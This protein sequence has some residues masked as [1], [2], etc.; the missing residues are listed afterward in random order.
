MFQIL[1]ICM[2]IISELPI[3]KD[4]G[5]S[6]TSGHQCIR[7]YLPVVIDN[8]KADILNKIDTHS[9]YGFVFYIKRM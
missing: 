3:L 5:S 9:L 1:T 7:H 8:L 4:V 6:M 2:A